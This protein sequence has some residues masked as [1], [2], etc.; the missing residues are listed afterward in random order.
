MSNLEKS[1]EV[2]KTNYMNARHGIF[3]SRNIVGDE[4]ETIYEDEGLT[5]DICYYY[6]YFEVFGLS[7]EEFEEL[8]T[9]YYSLKESEADV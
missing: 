2:I 9:Y 5:I 6:E 1:K 8:A 7:D 3:D 4:M